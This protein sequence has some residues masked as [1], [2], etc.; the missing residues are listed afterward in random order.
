MPT[1]PISRCVRTSFFP[2][3]EQFS[4]L[5][6]TD[7]L[8]VG[9]VEARGGHSVSTW[10][11]SSCCLHYT[12]LLRDARGFAGG[13]GLWVP[14]G[15]LRSPRKSCAFR[16][17]LNKRGDGP[18]IKEKSQMSNISGTIFSSRR[19]IRL[20]TTDVFSTFL[21]ILLLL[22]SDFKCTSSQRICDNLLPI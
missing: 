4:N 21:S 9:E 10:R 14:R 2:W 5:I 20:T 1:S 12:M 3:F 18:P 16:R 6:R 13:V 11:V 7:Y 19:E 15:S 22:L 17:S 8:S